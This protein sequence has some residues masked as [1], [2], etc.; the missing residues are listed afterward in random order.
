MIA[1]YTNTDPSY[2]MLYREDINARMWCVQYGGN[3]HYF[4]TVDE[5]LDYMRERWGKREKGGSTSGKLYAVDTCSDLDDIGVTY[6]ERKL[7]RSREAAEKRA[8]YINFG[9]EDDGY[10]NYAMVVEFEVAE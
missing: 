4:E 3:G 7:Y 8:E 5:A 6:I 1:P 9:N 10:R 2:P